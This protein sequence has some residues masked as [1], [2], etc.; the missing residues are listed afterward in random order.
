MSSSGDAY[1][2]SLNVGGLAA[3]HPVTADSGLG[4]SDHGRPF[5]SLDATAMEEESGAEAKTSPNAGVNF[6]VVSTP[7][8]MNRLRRRTTSPQRVIM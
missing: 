7:K 6:A 1:M 5:A 2:V 3:A 8:F 4:G